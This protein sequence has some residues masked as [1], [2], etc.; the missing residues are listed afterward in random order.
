MGN[1]DLGVLRAW[2]SR[3]S[4]AKRLARSLITSPVGNR[5]PPS[6]GPFIWIKKASIID[7][8]WMDCAAA[9]AAALCV[10]PVRTALARATHARHAPCRAF[11][12]S[13]S[14][15]KE[16]ACAGFSAAQDE[17]RDHN[18]TPS[19]RTH[20]IFQR[21]GDNCFQTDMGAGDQHEIAAPFALSPK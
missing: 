6:S 1:D 19:R 10:N 5:E 3:A 11:N 2:L 8:A 9:G 21:A 17:S 16:G 13:A 7:M 4:S 18:S 15:M 12:S 20:L 14:V